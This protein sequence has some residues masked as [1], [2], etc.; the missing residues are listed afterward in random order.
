MVKSGGGQNIARLKL[1]FA[2]YSGGNN[3]VRE[4]D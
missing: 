4:T 2:N 1:T 3:Y